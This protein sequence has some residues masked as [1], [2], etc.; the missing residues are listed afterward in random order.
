MLYF[1]NAGVPVYTYLQN[2]AK[3]VV[4]LTSELKFNDETLRI[5]DSCFVNYSAIINRKKCCDVTQEV[6]ICE[7]P[8]NFS[9][10]VKYSE[11]LNVLY[12]DINDNPKHLLAC[13]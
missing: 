3:C 6:F 5:Y 12:K 7:K 9:I 2:L 10:S 8:W 11:A 13:G 4:I 1:H